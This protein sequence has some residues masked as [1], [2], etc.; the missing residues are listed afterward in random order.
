M[1]EISQQNSIS[2][3]N[4]SPEMKTPYTEERPRVMPTLLLLPGLDGT[5][6]IFGPLLRH[7]PAEIKTRVVCYPTDRALTFQEHVDFARTQFPKG[8]FVLLAESFSGPIGLQLLAKPPENLVGVLFVATFA[9]HPSPFILDAAQFLP[10]KLLL[11]LFSKTFLGRFVCIAGAS[12]DATK[13]FR[14]AL[15][16]V[17]LSV[18]SNRL[19]ILAELPPPPETS[20]SGPCLYLQASTDRLVPQRAVVPLQQLLPQLQ[21]VQ[22]PG[23]HIILLAHPETGARLIG[24]FIANAADA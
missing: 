1:L 23:P 2:A 16:S 4:I 9:R 17:K 10:Q 18:L 5:G 6:K 24:D 11:N 20:F 21:V 15:N 13:I 19:K 3:R 8:P 12:A 22:V 14:E 7:L